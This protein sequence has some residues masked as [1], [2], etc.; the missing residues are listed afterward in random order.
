MHLAD[1]SITP[2]LLVTDKA[3]LVRITL[4]RQASAHVADMSNLNM[5]NIVALDID[6]REDTMYWSDSN[7]DKIFAANTD[8]SNF[9]EVMIS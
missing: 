1:D 4:D 9:R 6:A 2:Y 7:S 8:G 5:T 3:S